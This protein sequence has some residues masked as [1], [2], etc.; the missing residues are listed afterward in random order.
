MVF[1]G[2]EWLKC[3]KQMRKCKNG[4]SKCSNVK[5]WKCENAVSSDSSTDYN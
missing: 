1:Y 4:E 2:M 5:M 3:G